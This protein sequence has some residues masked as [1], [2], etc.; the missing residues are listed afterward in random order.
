MVF[1]ESFE[2]SSSLETISLD[3]RSLIF[4]IALYDSKRK[5]DEKYL[6]FRIAILTLLKTMLFQT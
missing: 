3:P 1:S 2:T 5:G 4:A 6:N